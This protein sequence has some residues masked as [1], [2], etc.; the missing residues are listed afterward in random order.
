MK[1]NVDCMLDGVAEF[2]ARKCYPCVQ[3]HRVKRRLVRNKV[4][5]LS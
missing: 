4:M 3:D 5:N 1:F 2:S